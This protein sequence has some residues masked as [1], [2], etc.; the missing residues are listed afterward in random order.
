MTTPTFNPGDRVRSTGYKRGF[1]G[2]VESIKPEWPDG[3]TVHVRAPDVE[4]P[5]DLI[6][7]SPDELELLP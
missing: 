7:F 3:L 6:A 4:K 1:T 5:F 2:T